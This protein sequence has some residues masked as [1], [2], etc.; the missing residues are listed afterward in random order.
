MRGAI[1][2]H[3]KSKSITSISKSC[4]RR[5]FGRRD[6]CHDIPFY[7][8]LTG[9]LKPGPK[10]YEGSLPQPRKSPSSS[11][12]KVSGM[13]KLCSPFLLSCGCWHGTCHPRQETPFLSI[14]LLDQISPPPPHIFLSLR[15]Q[16][17]PTQSGGEW[18]AW[19]H[20]KTEWLVGPGRDREGRPG[21]RKVSRDFIS[22]NTGSLSP[23]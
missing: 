23:E 14:L 1:R 16:R 19:W 6:L 11:L 22:D 20:D 5:L 12:S 18:V 21:H 13:R 9:F 4:V 10:Y 8:T 7:L 2:S 15:I 3:I 17:S